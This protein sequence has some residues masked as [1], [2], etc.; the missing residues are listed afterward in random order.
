ME[1]VSNKYKQLRD[2]ILDQYNNR[3]ADQELQKLLDVAI[4]SGN[5]ELTQTLVLLHNNYKADIQEIKVVTRD[6]LLKLLDANLALVEELNKTNKHMQEKEN[7]LGGIL[8]TI[9]SVGKAHGSFTN[10]QKIMITAVCCL[11]AV[12]LMN[13]WF[14]NAVSGAATALGGL[15]HGVMTP[16]GMTAKDPNAPD[17]SSG[18]N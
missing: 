8:S 13:S 14:P 7:E 18:G 16:Q 6:T 5:S 4:K 10:L 2:T 15:L 9:K 12:T 3:S 1:N 17:T 11:F